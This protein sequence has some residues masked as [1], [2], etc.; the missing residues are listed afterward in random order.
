M[1][2]ISMEKGRRTFPE[3]SARLLITLASVLVCLVLAAG[4]L[5]ADSPAGALDNNKIIQGHLKILK[6]PTSPLEIRK[7]AA[8]ILMDL[9]VPGSKE[10]L[11]RILTDPADKQA[12]LAVIEAIG[13]RDEPYSEFLQPLIEILLAGETDLQPAAT[14]A[15]GRFHNKKLTEQLIGIAGDTKRTAAQRLAAI[16]TLGKMR[17]KTTVEALIK[18]LETAAASPRGEQS[19]FAAACAKSLTEL[20]RVDLGANL[21][22]WKSWWERNRNKTKDQ[23]LESQ[24]DVVVN[25]NRELKKRLELTETALIDRLGQ[26]FRSSSTNEAERIKIIQGYLAGNLPAERRA[27]LELLTVFV[28]PKQPIP[29][30]LG[31]AIRDIIDD[32]DPQVRRLCAK[33]L[34]DSQDHLAVPDMLK[35][36]DVETDPTVKQAL[37]LALGQL[38]DRSLVDKLIQQLNSPLEPVSIGAT[39]ALTKLFQNKKKISSAQ[40]N[41]VILA[42]IKRYKQAGEDQTQLKQ[43][44]LATMGIIGSYQFHLLFEQELSS[45]SAN[46]RIFA[47]RGLASLGDETLVNLLKQYLNDSEAGVRAEVAGDIAFLTSDPTAVEILLTRTNPNIEKDNQVRQNTWN[48]ILT[49]V[50]KWRIDEQL[51]WANKLTLRDDSISQDQMAAL[52]DTLGLQIQDKMADLTTDQKIALNIA[53][54]KFLLKTPRAE[55]SVKYFR[56]VI[57]LGKQLAPEKPLEFANKLLNELFQI[58][59]PD[60]VIAQYFNNLLGVLEPDQLESM[61][62]R[63]LE[64]ADHAANAKSATKICRYLS[65]DLLNNIPDN[66]R[67]RLVCLAKKFKPDT[68][69]VSGPTRTNVP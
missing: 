23:W 57:S 12:R 47:A 3:G 52:A 46:L 51:Q 22:A 24:L 18:F 17:S 30:A 42:L 66:L 50:K 37:L 69:P 34:G 35:Q 25:E 2:L 32:T 15:L 62:N 38:G 31:P 55:D 49:M 61:I 64:W 65:K 40:E 60:L 48:A 63:L 11:L 19:E 29:S 27:G 56:Q 14:N 41:Q 58:P 36:L 1:G 43:E 8:T 44:L 20:T 59:A 54:G 68:V 13:D 9:E 16:D 28:S 4:P 39:R 21:N 5:F 67:T 7:T 45:T 6:S 33:V 53:F 26:I 10:Q